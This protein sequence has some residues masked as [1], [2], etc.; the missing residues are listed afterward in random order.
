MFDLSGFEP[1]NSF[2]TAGFDALKINGVEDPLIN[3]NKLATLDLDESYTAEAN[4]FIN[5]MNT[6][7]ADAKIEFYRAVSESANEFEIQ[8]S[9]IS[10]V[11][12]I[13]KI[14]KKVVAFI[15][16]LAG[17]AIAKLM[18]KTS[19]QRYITSHEKDFKSFK[20]DMAFQFEGYQYSFDPQ[21]PRAEA[22]MTFN[23]SLFNDLYGGLDLTAR[24]VENVVRDMNNES[25]YDTFRAQVL[26]LEGKQI[27]I[28]E[29]PTVLFRIFRSGTSNGTMSTIYVTKKYLSDAFDRVK[30]K[31]ELK[32]QIEIGESEARSQY[33][34]IEDSLKKI[35]AIINSR[36]V[37]ELVNNMPGDIRISP[38]EIANDGRNL[39]ADMASQLSAYINEKV[40]EI[41]QYSAIHIQAFSAKLE[42]IQACYNQDMSTLYQAYNVI[43]GYSVEE[44]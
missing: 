4:E 37:D 11:A 1:T 35:D 26:G 34:K 22:L 15:T 2:Y 32:K 13:G 23:Q 29:Y 38:D 28:T 41:Q 14:I 9:F 30:N 6:Q 43:K 12:Y 8:E 21:I 42:A 25:K 27:S 7:V 44:G 17:K 24:E 33:K 36:N 19:N 3:V 18:E 20:D 16:D 39:A 40:A 5:E 31:N 10:L